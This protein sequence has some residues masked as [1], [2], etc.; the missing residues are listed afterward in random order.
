MFLSW[1]RVSVAG[2]DLGDRQ[3]LEQRYA[4]CDPPCLLDSSDGR[5]AVHSQLNFVCVCV[6]VCVCGINSYS[7]V[8]C[9]NA[10]VR[11]GIDS[12]SFISTKNYKFMSPVTLCSGGPECQWFELLT[13]H[14]ILIYP[15][16]EYFWAE[17]PPKYYTVPRQWTARLQQSLH[18][19]WLIWG[20]NL[21]NRQG[22]RMLDVTLTYYWR[23]EGIIS[24]N[25][26]FQCS[27]FCVFNVLWSSSIRVQW[28]CNIHCE[29]SAK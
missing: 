28:Q 16:S 15:S 24:R 8:S 4:G 29:Q 17:L 27:I 9:D 6:C 10:H 5:W 2:L 26:P 14:E 3:V 18:W 1:R 23:L 12:I 22:W 19:L 25:V 11:H 20:Y 13:V 21:I 7:C